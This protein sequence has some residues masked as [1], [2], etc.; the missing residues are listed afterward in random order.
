MIDNVQKN[1]CNNEHNDTDLIE[2]YLFLNKLKIKFR[3]LLKIFFFCLILMMFI[4]KN[5]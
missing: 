2:E 3:S 5:S 1:I 4:V